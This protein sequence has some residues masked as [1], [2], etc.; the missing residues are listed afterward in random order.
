[1]VLPDAAAEAVPAPTD[2]EEQGVEQEAAEE[3]EVRSSG[4]GHPAFMAS[5]F[6]TVDVVK[7]DIACIRRGAVEI[8]AVNGEALLAST[9]KEEKEL[10]RRL[11]P[12]VADTN[13]RAKHCKAFL[14]LMKEENKALKAGGKTKVS[15]FAPPRSE[16]P[17]RAR[18]I[19]ARDQAERAPANPPPSHAPRSRSC[20]SATTCTRRSRASSSTR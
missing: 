1:V 16:A 4:A 17:D 5:F 7:G 15:F 9:N 12:I 20:G 6:K 8:G 19:R 13:K 3:P 18:D 11:K 14:E 10:S 2:L